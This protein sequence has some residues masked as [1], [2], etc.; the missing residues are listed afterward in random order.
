MTRWPALLGALGLVAFGF[1][2]L[3]AMLALFNPL[4]DLVLVFANLMVGVLLLAVAGVGLG[5]AALLRRRPVAS[6]TLRGS[7]ATRS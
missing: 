5:L 2:L 4:A 3:S 7:N 1:G 6:A